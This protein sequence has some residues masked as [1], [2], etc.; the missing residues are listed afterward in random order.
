MH[1]DYT[2]STLPKVDPRNKSPRQYHSGCYDPVFCTFG[3]VW[4]LLVLPK[5]P[6]V[7]EFGNCSAG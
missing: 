7:E 4:Q 2:L 5:I 3:I 6:P 1:S